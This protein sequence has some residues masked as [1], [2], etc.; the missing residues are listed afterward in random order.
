MEHGG[1]GRLA[2]QAKSGEPPYVITW[3]DT[4]ENIDTLTFVPVSSSISSDY[5]LKTDETGV[6][7]IY[8][9]GTMIIIR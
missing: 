4:P 1:W 9:G 2:A 8:V 6:K 5:F 3:N 7:L